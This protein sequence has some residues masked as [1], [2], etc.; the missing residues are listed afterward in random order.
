L[1]AVVDSNVLIA[2]LLSPRGSPGRAFRT[3]L[4]GSYELI[5]SPSL[6]AELDRALAY[7][8]LR[9]R[10]PIENAKALVD[11]LRGSATLADDPPEG[12][13]PISSRDPGDDYLLALA[14]SERAAL[15]TGDADL[16]T[17]ATPLP[18]Y[19]PAA[20]IDLIDRP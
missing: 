12:S 4:E 15:V 11:L 18:I 13:A 9:S 17:I 10:I 2:A 16:L 3:W 19:S 7:P 5:V 8:K 1:R 14:I 6:L 20:F